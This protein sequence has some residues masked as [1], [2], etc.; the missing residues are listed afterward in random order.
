MHRLPNR[1]TL[2]LL[3]KHEHTQGFHIIIRLTIRY[4]RINS[5]DNASG[6]PHCCFDNFFVGILLTLNLHIRIQSSSTKPEVGIIA[7][8]CRLFVDMHARNLLQQ[9]FIQR[10]DMFMMG[11]MVI[12]YRHLT[13]TNTSTHIRHTIVIANSTV[14]IVRISITSLCS[15][16]HHLVGILRITANQ[17]T[18]T[19]SSNHLVAIERQHTIFSK[20]TQYLTIKTRTHSLSS[21]LYY[22]N[23]ILISYCH[24]FINT[25]R[26][27]IKSHRH[28]RFRI[29][30]S[31]F[32][33][34]NNRLLQQSWIHIPSLAFRTNKYRLGSKVCDRM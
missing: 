29:F 33:A 24:D 34:V 23:A 15:I 30:A 5:M 11:N 18:S 31:L 3:A 2:H 9:F 6:T 4:R 26:H 8:I 20:C 22:R 14:L 27:T 10:L 25:V 28:N 16:P 21:I 12:Q 32:L 19:R 1:T 13:T 7:R 17:R